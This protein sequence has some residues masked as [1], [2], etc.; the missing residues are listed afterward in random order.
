MKKKVTLYL[1]DVKVKKARMRALEFDKS[2]SALVE[3]MIDEMLSAQV[4]LDRS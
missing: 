4:E 1:D 2:F 3:G